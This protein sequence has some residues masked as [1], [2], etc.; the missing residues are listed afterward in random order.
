MGLDFSHC[1]ASWAYSGFDRFRKRLA[2]DIGF[3][4]YEHINT[5]NDPLYEKIKDDGLLPL[6]AHSDCDGEL[7]PEECLRV[8]PRLR[9]IVGNWPDTD[10]DKSRA[11]ELAAGMEL[12]A[13]ENEPL[14]FI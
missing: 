5:T 11:L 3:K 8:A 4:E 2:N 9:E 10:F 12:A 6:L 7:T 14:K 1:D 13:S